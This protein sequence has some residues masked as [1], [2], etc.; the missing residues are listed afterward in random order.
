MTLLDACGVVA[1][2]GETEILHGVSITVGMGEVVT[3]IG[4]NGCG[5]STLDEG[6]R[7]SDS[8]AIGQHHVPGRGHIWVNTKIGKRFQNAIATV[9]RVNKYIDE[10]ERFI[11]PPIDTYNSTARTRSWT[12]ELA[13]VRDPLEYGIGVELGL[14]VLDR[15]N[16]KVFWEVTIETFSYSSDPQRAIATN[17]APD[18]SYGTAK[19]PGQT[20]TGQP[21]I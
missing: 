16:D 4:P 10:V 15:D 2:Y 5:K 7:R 11:R 19:P 6:H 1:G 14:R 12:T 9:D 3:I 13:I 8:D 18:K 20:L 21:L 17:R